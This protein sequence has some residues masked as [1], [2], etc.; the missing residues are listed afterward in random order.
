VVPLVLS[1]ALG[2]GLY[3]LYEGF[4]RPPSP[5]AAP[6]RRLRAVEDFLVRAG[7][8]VS[9]GDF[10]LFSLGAGL[11][12]GLGAQLLLGWPA[13][14]LVAAGVGAGAPLAY[15]ARRHDRR[16]ATT[17]AAL[18]EALERL[19]DAVRSGLAV[20]EALRSLSDNGPEALRPEFVQLRRDLRLLGL[21][22]ALE[23]MARR[24]ASPT[25]DLCA[26]ALA[27]ND[28]VGGRN[29]SAVLDRLA[30]ASRAQLR[31]RRELEAQQARHVLSARVVAAVPVLV[32]VAVR[33]ASP[34][35]LA[36][37]DTAPGQLV[38][39]GCAA[40]VAL[41]YAAMRWIARLP[42]EPRVL[43]PREEGTP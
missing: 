21:E 26:A 22:S 34:S 37:F 43:R 5:P 30:E 25:W 41:G 35:Y 32:V 17:E 23:A 3:L 6:R 15:Y 33:G 7:L 31:A 13:V 24:L 40:S 39:V 8:D 18:V 2:A 12:A 28:R 20:G 36:V 1:V 14:G 19:R 42:D 10:V 27:L 4:T 38:L 9:P 16:R 11:L 29:V